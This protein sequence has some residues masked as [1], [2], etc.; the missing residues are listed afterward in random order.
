MKLYVEQAVIADIYELIAFLRDDDREEAEAVVGSKY[1]LPPLLHEFNHGIGDNYSVFHAE[2]HKLIAVGGYDLTGR[3]WFMMTK[4]PLIFAERKDFLKILQQFKR[5]ALAHTSVLW[6]QVMMDNTEHV[7][8][9][10]FLGATFG[11]PQIYN[12]RLFKTFNIG[13]DLWD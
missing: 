6:N 12:G 1:I 11:D 2:S 7:R 10:T 9:L 4:E 5:K 13:G 8:L 3:V